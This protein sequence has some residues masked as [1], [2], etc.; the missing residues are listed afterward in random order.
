MNIKIR[1]YFLWNQ[2][3]QDILKF[4]FIQNRYNLSLQYYWTIWFKRLKQ[5]LRVGKS[6]T[7]WM[8]DYL[9]WQSSPPKIFN[10]KNWTDNVSANETTTVNKWNEQ[11]WKN[12]VLD[13]TILIISKN[14]SAMYF[15]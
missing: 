6:N 13:R 3:S 11:E 14:G 4:L 12:K 2:Y 8:L 1:F 10:H 15:M 7:S 5:R 9:G